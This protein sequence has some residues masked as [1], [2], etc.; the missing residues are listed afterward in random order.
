MKSFRTVSIGVVGLAAILAR[1]QTGSQQP[2]H[3]VVDGTPLVFNNQQ[4]TKSN[5]RVLVPLRGIFERLGAVVKWDPATQSVTAKRGRR[6]VK[7]SIGLLDASIDGHDAH[8]DVPAT[9]VG[10]STMVPLRFVSESL[11]ATVKWNDQDQEADITSPP[12]DFAPPVQ[13]PV[14]IIQPAPAAYDV[15]LEDSVIPFRLNNRLSSS[16][17]R[18]GDQF[19]ATLITYNHH[20][21]LGLPE[22]T[23]AYGHVAY[24][25]PRRGYEPGVLELKFDR[26][27][28]PRGTSFQVDGRLIGLDGGSVNR[29]GDG[30]FMI[31]DRTRF[32]R[33]A[34]T[35]LGSGVG[36]VIGIRNSGPITDGAFHDFLGVEIG[37]RHPNSKSYRDVQLAPGA[38]FG[39]H[40]HHQITF[41]HNVP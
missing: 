24:A 35:G 28:T 20:R 15:I 38:Q 41:R 25:H 2:I 39:L 14:R 12:Q 8:L 11:G 17:A 31:K 21:Y 37:R 13:P 4:P 40:L 29:G 3:V 27:A 19:S 34:F 6:T 23:Q 22:G 18:S 5:N 26:I 30:V 1:A 7:L 16:N 10:G 32:D 33:V 9:L 36:L